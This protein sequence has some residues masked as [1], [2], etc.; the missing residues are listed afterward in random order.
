MS[1]IS[2]LDDGRDYFT[3]RVRHDVVVIVTTGIEGVMW[4]GISVYFYRF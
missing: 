3:V 4:L 1:Q 2:S